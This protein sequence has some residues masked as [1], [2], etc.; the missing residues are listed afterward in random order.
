ML[1]HVAS[2]KLSVPEKKLHLRRHF[3]K[4]EKNLLTVKKIKNKSNCIHFHSYNRLITWN[5]QLKKNPY[6][7]EKF[8]VKY[9]FIS[10]C[11]RC[12]DAIME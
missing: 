2:K 8:E 10:S 7:I 6:K 1:K 4:K 11:G 9:A 5:K 12:Y 3:N